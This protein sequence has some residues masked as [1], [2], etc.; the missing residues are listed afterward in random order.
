[1]ALAH[2]VDSVNRTQDIQVSED[3]TFDS[4]LLCS[5]TLKGLK[6]S[7]FR[8]PSPI[9]LL[10]IPLGKC[11][12]DLLLEAK[13]GTGKTAVFIIIAL[14]KLDINKGL[15]TIVLAPTREIASQICDVFKQIGCGYKGLN[16]ELVI[17]GLSVDEDMKKF[18]QTVHVLVASPGR[19]KHL[20]QISVI[21]ISAVRLLIIDEA[22]K[23][24]EKS[25][26]ADINYI[27]S[28]LPSQKQVI[29][30][31]AT[32]SEDCKKLLSNYTKN[33]QHVCP[34]SN[35][36][37][38]GVIQKSTIVKSNVNIVKQTQYRFTELLKIISKKQFKQCLIFCNYQVRVTELHRMLAKE[39]WPVEL[40]YSKQEQIDRLDA[41]KTLQ[42][43]KCRILISTD[44]AARGIDASNVDLVINFEPPFEWQTY[45]HRI[46]RAGRFG[47]YG[48][49]VTI[50][51]EGKEVIKFR[52]LLKAMKSSIIIQDFWTDEIFELDSN[53]TQTID[54]I[55][56]FTE[57]TAKAKTSNNYIYSVFWNMLTSENTKDMKTNIDSF[58]N[59][60]NFY[61][62][63]KEY[64]IQSFSDLV[65]SFD[66]IQENENQDNATYQTINVNS[67]PTEELLSIISSKTLVQSAFTNGNHYEQTAVIS[68]K[69]GNQ[70]SIKSSTN[71]VEHNNNESVGK[72]TGNKINVEE[73]WNYKESHYEDCTKLMI[74]LGLPTSFSSKPRSDKN[75]HRGHNTNNGLNLSNSEPAQSHVPGI[76]NYKQHK[77]N[78][79][80]GNQCAMLGHSKDSKKSLPKTQ[81][82][83]RQ[84]KSNWNIDN[85]KQ[86]QK[87]NYEY[88]SLWYNQFKNHIK[89]IEIA[90]YLNEMSKS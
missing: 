50:L 21:D 86:S 33:V 55:N 66:S 63:S 48:I 56:S 69:N 80:K 28:I 82:K 51:S 30:S 7:G 70:S 76:P 34:D 19:L 47:S 61:E 62:N 52:N 23:L 39:Q 35:C 37:L 15:Q 60:L 27:F 49:A 65:K 90:F 46:G 73:K 31:S 1:M 53:D 72:D 85:S 83:A 20:I 87:M 11:G 41:L 24:M 40:L 54:A 17:G 2:D 38:K 89:N 64:G 9:Q 67:L 12:F 22:D 4:M 5:K 84:R 45:L 6:K 68:K 25:F 75:I 78:V 42:E 58:D 77:T 79:Q 14:E 88:Y 57:N 10:G 71:V 36:I 13:S 43:Y 29:M 44:L 74:N 16:V 81:T 8:Y 32:Y 18:S 59:L 26:I 3:V